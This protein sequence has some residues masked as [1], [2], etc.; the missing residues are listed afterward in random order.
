MEDLNYHVCLSGIAW[1]QALHS[2]LN[3][4]IKDQISFSKITPNDDAEYEL[5]L[6]QVGRAYERR[7]QEK[8][9]HNDHKPK[10][11]KNNK[12]KRDDDGD[13]KGNQGKKNFEKGSDSKK[14]RTE[15][16]G[17][18]PVNVDKGEALKGIPESLLEARAKRNECKHCGS[19]DHRWVFCKNAIK[20]SSS[21]KKKKDKKP[22]V[23][24]S[25]VTTSSSK[26]KPR[27]LA[28]RITKP[29]A[30]SSSRVLYEVDSDGMEID[31]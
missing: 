13:D 23:Q 7:L 29:A 21:K 8:H 5:L 16:K 12:R 19:S 17:P 15:K 14:P 27:S 31:V 6:K 10:D 26:V 22:K 2:G 11:K 18:K 20:V 25:E 3:E 28:D 9:H 1:Q 30:A 24:T 4:E